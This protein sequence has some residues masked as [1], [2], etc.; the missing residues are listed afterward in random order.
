[1]REKEECI[2]SIKVLKNK[3]DK[4]KKIYC[5]MFLSMKFK[6]FPFPFFS[7]F[8]MLFLSFCYVFDKI[9]IS[10]FFILI[11]LSQI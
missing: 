1:M 6:S 9:K 11:L 8:I 10:N 7:I 2:F 3:E 4:E 5:I